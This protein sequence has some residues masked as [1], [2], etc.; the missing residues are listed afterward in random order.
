LADVKSRMIPVILDRVMALYA[1]AVEAS[2]CIAAGMRN[3]Y[4]AP[5]GTISGAAKMLVRSIPA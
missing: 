1:L 3:V 4:L 5:S 2:H